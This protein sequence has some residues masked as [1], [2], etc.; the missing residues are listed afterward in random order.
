MTVKGAPVDPLSLLWEAQHEPPGFGPV[1]KVVDRY[2]NTCAYKRAWTGV[3]T[4][5]GVVTRALPEAFW[6]SNGGVELFHRVRAG[7][8]PVVQLD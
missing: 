3:Q 2:G 4:S 7:N 5:A 6:T 1:L 8:L